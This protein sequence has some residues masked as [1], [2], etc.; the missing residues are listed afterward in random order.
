MF[1]APLLV[2]WIF[3]DLIERRYD[4]GPSP[5]L[6]APGSRPFHCPDGDSSGLPVL[7]LVIFASGF[8]IS[9]RRLPDRRRSLSTPYLAPEALPSQIRDSVVVGRIP[10][11]SGNRR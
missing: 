7:V 8:A 10:A 5:N 4:S 2:E 1:V 9:A 11:M 3:T 6:A